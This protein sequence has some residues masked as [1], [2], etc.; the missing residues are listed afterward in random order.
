MSRFAFSSCFKV[1]VMLFYPMI[2]QKSSAFAV[3]PLQEE[4]IVD[5]D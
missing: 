3:D 4:Y 1:G 2:F 5:Y